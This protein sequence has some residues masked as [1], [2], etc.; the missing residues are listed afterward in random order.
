MLAS[1]AILET[2]PLVPQFRKW[3]EE[4]KAS[5]FCDSFLQAGYDMESIAAM[6]IKDM[7]L[8]Y[9]KAAKSFDPSGKSVSNSSSVNSKYCARWDLRFKPVLKNSSIST[10]IPCLTSFMINILPISNYTK[11]ARTYPPKN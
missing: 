3:L 10:S 5:E 9:H 2:D 8:V 1:K 4:L 6:G 7:I 11:G